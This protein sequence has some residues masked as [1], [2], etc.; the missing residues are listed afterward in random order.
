MWILKILAGNLAIVFVIELSL[1]V[2]L[3]AKTIRKIITM[4]LVNIIT[5]PAVVLSGMC[6][7]LF[8]SRWESIGICIL[9]V[10]VVVTEGFMF[11]KFKTFDRKNPYLI[12]LVLNVASFAVGEV[13]NIFL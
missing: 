2:L 1:G 4:V 12:S 9:E 10:L 7:T 8:L 13:I 6:L 11:W 3:G 5:N